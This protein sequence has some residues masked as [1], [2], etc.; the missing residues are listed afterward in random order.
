MRTVEEL[1]WLYGLTQRGGERTVSIPKG[2]DVLPQL[3]R[4][5]QNQDF[6]LVWETAVA[7]TS[8]LSS[9]PFWRE[10]IMMT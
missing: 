10:Y 8:E 4:N 5:G 3:S 6:L 7:S 1:S 9:E 2:S